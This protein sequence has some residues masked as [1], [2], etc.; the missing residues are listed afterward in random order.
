MT[1]DE[2]ATPDETTRN[3]PFGPILGSAIGVPILGYGLWGM[4]R[5]SALTHPPDAAAWIVGSAVVNDLLLLPLL[6]VV[7]L[8]ATRPLPAWARPPAR[9]GLAISVVLALVAWPEISDVGGDPRNPSVLPRDELAGLLAY[10]GVV[11]LV[12]TLALVHRA[13]ARVRARLSGRGGGG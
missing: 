8:V 13:R 10:L 1:V 2:S 7:G 6:T 12:V 5:D 11:W 3:I 4:L 9:L